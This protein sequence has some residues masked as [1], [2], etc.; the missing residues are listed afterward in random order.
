VALLRIGVCGGRPSK[1]NSAG[2][3]TEISNEL[4]ALLD[5]QTEFLKTFSHT[6]AE[7]REYKHTCDRVRELF[8]EMA[9]SN[10]EQK[11]G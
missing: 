7:L 4:T 9:Q 3:S 11:A 6:P 10:A 1:K 8:A 5:W 2:S